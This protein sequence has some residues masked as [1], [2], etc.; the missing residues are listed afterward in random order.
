MSAA[1]PTQDGRRQPVTSLLTIGL[2]LD[3]AAAH[4]GH[5]L[6]MPTV[7]AAVAKGLQ[8]F[9]A[10]PDLFHETYFFVPDDDDEVDNNN[11]ENDD[12]RIRDEGRGV[13][14]ES[15][16]K[17]RGGG[18]QGRPWDGVCI[19]WGLRGQPDMTVVF[20]RMV[21][22]VR[23]ASPGSRLVFAG[24]AA[25]HFGTAKRNWPNLRKVDQ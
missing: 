1:T 15:E 10:V 25:D 4:L 24:P 21:N 8:E 3:W 17:I 23:E 16:R 20:E 7:R 19:G 11:Q 13:W 2:D 9:D 6:D 12:D 14:A 5:K 22:L 18:H